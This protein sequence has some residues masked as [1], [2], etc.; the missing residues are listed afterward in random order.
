M[1]KI[2]GGPSKTNGIKFKMLV[3]KVLVSLDAKL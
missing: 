2:A 1:I 3:I